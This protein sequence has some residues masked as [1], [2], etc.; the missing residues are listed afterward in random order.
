MTRATVL[1]RLCRDEGAQVFLLRIGDDL[2]G[3]TR[4]FHDMITLPFSE[5]WV[6]SL[7]NYLTNRAFDLF[8][9]D[10]PRTCLEPD[11]RDLLISLRAQKKILI[12][13]D[14]DHHVQDC[15]HLI[16]IPAI[17]VADVPSSQGL[18]PRVY[19]WDCLLLK[20]KT[21]AQP[22]TAGNRVLVLTGGSDVANLGD[23]WPT[24]LDQYLKNT[25]EI[26]W[27]QGPFSPSPRLPGQPNLKF[28]VHSCPKD[29]GFLMKQAHYAVS[30]F[31]VTFFELC[32]VGIPTVVFSPYGKR[33]ASSLEVIKQ[34]G[35]AGV[36]EDA[37]DASKM[38]HALM[39]DQNQAMQFSRTAQ[40]HCSVQKKHRFILEMN[41]LVKS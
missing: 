40:K 15:F 2:G 1:Y 3:W 9:F 26:H 14:H 35:C 39:Q 7:K 12:S 27:V 33:D 36:A 6:W 4:D 34:Q 23:C 19:G 8:I 17:S 32:A 37:L 10:L 24:Y 28:I 22:W 16:F 21:R 25:S 13:I 30:I 11:F 38:L 5:Q 20:T 29:I 18:T 41:R 31:G